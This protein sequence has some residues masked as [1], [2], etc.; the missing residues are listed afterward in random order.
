MADNQVG[1]ICYDVL[2]IGAGIAGLSAAS[3]LIKHGVNNIRVLEARNRYVRVYICLYC[4]EKF[5]P[6]WTFPCNIHKKYCQANQT[7]RSVYKRV[8]MISLLRMTAYID[9]SYG[10]PRGWWRVYES[11]SQSWVILHYFVLPSIV[12]VM[13][14]GYILKPCR[15]LFNPEFFEFCKIPREIFV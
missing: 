11:F 6:T 7:H 13:K 12:W 10:C 1:D 4:C 8:S 2:I 9:E 5:Y 15:I 14:T 3:H